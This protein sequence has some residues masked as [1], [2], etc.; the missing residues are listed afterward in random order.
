MNLIVCSQAYEIMCFE[1]ENSYH[2]CWNKTYQRR[3]LPNQKNPDWSWQKDANPRLVG[4]G[5]QRLGWRNEGFSGSVQTAL[6]QLQGQKTAQAER[7]AHR[8]G[9]L[10]ASLRQP[11]LGTAATLY[12]A[13]S[14]ETAARGREAPAGATVR[15]ARRHGLVSRS[16]GV[17][18]PRQGRVGA[19]AGGERRWREAGARRRAAT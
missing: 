8:A 16:A 18:S 3:Y 17:P 11:P 15:L 7:A 19:R 5:F 9:Q 2:S 4:A 12:R 1:G 10:P 13:G 14:R 6:A